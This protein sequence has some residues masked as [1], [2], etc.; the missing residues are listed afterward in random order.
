MKKL[1]LFLVL[2][3][4]TFQPLSGQNIYSA[5]HHNDSGKPDLRKDIGVIKII[6]ET[7]F[8]NQSGPEIEK[9][10]LLLNESNRIVLE[11]RYNERYNRKTRLVF[12]YDSTEVRCLNRRMDVNQPYVSISETAHYEYNKDGFLTKIT[13]ESNNEIFRITNIVN[14]ESGNPVL[15]EGYENSLFYGK[16]TADYDYENNIMKTTV[17]NSN[18]AIVSS[19]TGKINFS[20]NDSNDL[21]NEYGDLI[22]SD[23][24]KFEYKYD[25]KG[26]W[27][28]QTRYKLKN[29]IWVKNAIFIRIITYKK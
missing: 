10:E 6:Q 9:T 11:N 2:I 29:D 23:P 18:G 22:Q 7:T 24:F 14:D 16:E 5:L 8:F 27:K 4:I 19:N 15:L 17:Y 25:K 12:D 26:N 13:D 21:R 28:K 1:I 3:F 20:I